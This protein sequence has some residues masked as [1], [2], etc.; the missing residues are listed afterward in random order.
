MQGR[1]PSQLDSYCGELKVGLMF[2]RSGPNKDGK[3]TGSVCIAVKKARNLC[4]MN[5]RSLTNGYVQCYLLPDRSKSG[6]RKTKVINNSLDPVWDEELIYDKVV[7]DE[8][9]KERV[10]EVTVWNYNFIFSNDFIG[11]LCLG[12][13]SCNVV[14]RMKWMDSVRDEISHWEAMLAHPG[15]WVEQWHTLRPSMH[16]RA[17]NFSNTSG[18]SSL[19]PS[20]IPVVGKQEM[21]AAALPTENKLEHRERLYAVSSSPQHKNNQSVVKKVSS[22]LQ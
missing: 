21:K 10:L 18:L 19:P 5:I 2:M 14:K 3:I 12:P 11:G 16:P 20:P 7:L 9:S 17:S 1:R 15:E 13:D 8:L 4:K 6:K 22:A